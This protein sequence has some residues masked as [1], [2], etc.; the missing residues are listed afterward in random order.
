MIQVSQAVGRY[1]PS[2]TGD[3]HLGNLRT[4][5]LA[6]LSARSQ[7]GRFLLRME[8]LDTPRVI[9]GSANKIL[10][11]LEWLGL[12]WDGP[13]MYQSSRINDYE[14]AMAKLMRQGLVYPCFCSRKDIQLASS[15]P[16]G[17][18]AVYSGVCRFLSSDEASDRARVKTPSYRLIVSD[19]LSKE[20]GDFIIKRAD[21]LFAYQLAVVVDD[22]EQGVNEVVRGADL[23]DSTSRQLYLASVLSSADANRYS[24][25]N[26][27]HAP[28]MSDNNGLRMSKRDGSESLSS[29]RNA[30]K[31]PQELLAFLINSLGFNLNSE[32]ISLLELLDNPEILN[33]MF[34]DF[35]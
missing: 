34:S 25:I 20:V 24:P 35:Q 22:L 18:T 29:W 13:V 28:L 3:L 4:A 16:H 19:H 8:D 5:V 30:G 17:Q 9:K 14:A 1:A 32:K 12:D 23:I 11:D 10:K 7:K 27:Y 2:P 31:G 15:A 33:K 26:Y 6:W 21:G